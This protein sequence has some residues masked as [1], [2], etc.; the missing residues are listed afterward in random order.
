MSQMEIVSEAVVQAGQDIA[1]YL[2]TASVRKAMGNERL[3]GCLPYHL[4]DFPE[5]FHDLIT[6]YLNEDIISV[7]A[8]YIAMKRE[9]RKERS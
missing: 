9:E 7:T 2:C 3:G 4:K 6:A 8:I 5:K 1:G